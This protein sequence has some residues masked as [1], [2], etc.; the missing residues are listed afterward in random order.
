MFHRDK[1]LFKTSNGIYNEYH[2]CDALYNFARNSKYWN[3]YS[4]SFTPIRK[5]NVIKHKNYIKKV[6]TNN[7]YISGKY[8]NEVHIKLIKHGF[9][10]E[11][12]MMILNDYLEYTQYTTL[13]HQASDRPDVFKIC[14]I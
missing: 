7:F 2:L 3:R 12:H 14:F 9:Y 4:Y 11:L 10:K 13:E 1:N 5:S 6:K 8:L